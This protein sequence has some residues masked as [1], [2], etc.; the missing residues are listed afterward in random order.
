ML[1]RGSAEWGNKKWSTSTMIEIT[2][3]LR[4]ILDRKVEEF[5]SWAQKLMVFKFDK[6]CKRRWKDSCCICHRRDKERLKII[7]NTNP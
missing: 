2:E 6:E 4:P 7:V 1:K 3:R 5:P